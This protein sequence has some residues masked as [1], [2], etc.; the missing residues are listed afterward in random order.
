MLIDY[1]SSR[2]QQDEIVVLSAVKTTPSIIINLCDKIL[3]NHLIYE[4]ACYYTNVNFRDE[5]LLKNKLNPDSINN[6]IQE[7]NCMKKLFE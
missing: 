6:M 3:I 4:T 1:A 5:F 7:L 2:L